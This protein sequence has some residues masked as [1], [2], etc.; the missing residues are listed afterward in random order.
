M[1]LHRVILSVFLP[2]DIIAINDHWLALVLEF[3]LFSF[4]LLPSLVLSQIV[5][6]SF[7]VPVQFILTKN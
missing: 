3:A 7:Y 1:A 4:D 2:L 6:T 5:I